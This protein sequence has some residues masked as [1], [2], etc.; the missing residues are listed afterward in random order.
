MHN[1]TLMGGLILVMAFGPGP[2]S[3][4]LWKRRAP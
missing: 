3:L 2:L 1:L 4:D